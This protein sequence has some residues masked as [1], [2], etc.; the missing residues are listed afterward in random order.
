M[1]RGAAGGGPR[2]Q[3]AVR[4]VVAFPSDLPA[5]M[6][7]FC[8]PPE[9]V[10]VGDCVPFVP[11]PQV[12][13]MGRRARQDLFSGESLSRKNSSSASTGEVG[14]APGHPR[15]VPHGSLL[16]SSEIR[17]LITC[18][19]LRSLSLELGPCGCP[20]PSLVLLSAPRAGFTEL[21]NGVLV[22]RGEA[23]SS[24]K[25]TWDSRGISCHTY[26]QAYCFVTSVSPPVIARQS[27]GKQILL[28]CI[29]LL[30]EPEYNFWWSISSLY[31]NLYSNNIFP[32]LCSQATEVML[33]ASFAACE[34]L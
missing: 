7:A 22:P 21:L 14:V 11:L 32:F 9:A 25:Q 15:C 29:W 18:L 16:L 2:P 4:V 5:A 17:S 3:R 8:G 20:A 31:S 30:Q 19:T 6:A 33:E 23:W 28:V 13:R 10:R 26:V 12:P 34:A 27:T 1:G 24:N